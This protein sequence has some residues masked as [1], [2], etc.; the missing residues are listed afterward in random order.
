MSERLRINFVLAPKATISGGPLAIL[1]Y[2]ERFRQRGH[3]VTITTYPDNMWRGDNPFPWF[4]FGGEIHYKRLRDSAG[5]A[6]PSLPAARLWANN[7]PA[8]LTNTLLRTVGIDGLGEIK[9]RSNDRT[10]SGSGFESL[11]TELVAGLH[12]VDVM[13]E[14]DL[15]IATFWT[16]ALPVFFCGKGKP[17]Y[18]MQHYEEVFHS[19]ET[20]SLL[21]RLCARASYQLPLFKVA[22]SS[23]LQRQMKQRF[24]QDVPFSNNALVLEDFSPKPKKS[25]KDGIIRIV[26]Y[27]NPFPWKGFADAV[28]AVTEI[29][30]RYGARVEWNVFGY[31]HPLLNE[32]SGDCPVKY[33]PKLSFPQLADLYATSDIALCP[34][35]YESF[36]L[37]PL[38]AMAS[39]TAVVTTDAGTEDYAFDGSNARVVGARRVDQMISA[40]SELIEDCELRTRLAREGRR[41]AEEFTWDRAVRDREEIL[42]AIHR[43]EV[44]Y[45]TWK[46]AKLGLL[47][48]NGIA[49]EDAPADL[50]SSDPSL[51]WRDDMLYLL[52]NNMRREVQ[53]SAVVPALLQNEISY[54]TIDE[55][56][57][58][59]TPAGPPI[60]SWADLP[61][62][63]MIGAVRPASQCK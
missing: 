43:G 32:S 45:D 18:F 48:G 39:G 42:M 11:V 25:E 10:T 33:H 15:N 1:E 30:K 51:F 41:T 16:T 36:P 62:D 26:T 57:F 14:C 49:F 35:W 38:E 2:A 23:W 4:K 29:R 44:T 34:S 52:H 58:A 61:R 31:R 37:P 50:P 63:F 59:R 46:P 53:C 9:W 19:L 6:S 24:G 21:Q 40:L 27:V 17:V 7:D 28:K 8:T 55:L 60:T 5:Q 47:D 13:P 22:N 54:L 3:V 20:S 56:I 12:V